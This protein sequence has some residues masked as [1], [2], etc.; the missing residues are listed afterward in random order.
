MSFSVPLLAF[1]SGA[2]SMDAIEAA[3]FF[4]KALKLP[5]RPAADSPVLIGLVHVPAAVLQSP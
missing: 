3:V 4:F 2:S 1:A 5:V